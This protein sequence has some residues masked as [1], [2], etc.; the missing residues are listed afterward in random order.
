MSDIYVE[1]EGGGT[2]WVSNSHPNI[3]EQ[4][5][6]YAIPFAGATL[7]DIEAWDE[8]G[9][10]IALSVQEEQTFTCNSQVI[11]IHVTFSPPKIHIYIDGDGSAYVTNEYPVTGDSVT[12][13]CDPDQG[14][15]V[16]RVEAYDENGNLV[17]MRA[18]KEQTFIWN[19]QTLDIYVKFGRVYTHRMPIWMY[20][21]L[22]E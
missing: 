1:Y 15:R 4:V 18:V 17:P 5:T 2:A 9:Y 11:T 3:G 13:H 8:G 19:Y 22:R 16:K 12:L 21:F 20:P 14:K 6:L 10:S 7:D